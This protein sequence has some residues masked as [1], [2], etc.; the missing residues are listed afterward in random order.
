MVYVCGKSE[1]ARKLAAS[2]QT[3]FKGNNTAKLIIPNKRFGQ[4]YDPFV[5]VDKKMSKELTEWV[6]CDL[7][8]K[9]PKKKTTYM[10]KSVLSHPPNSLCMAERRSKSSA[11]YLPWTHKYPEFKS[12]KGDLNGLGLDVDDIFAP[13]NFRNEHWI[14]ISI[15]I[16]KKHIVVWDSIHSHI[17]PEDLDVFS[18]KNAKAMREKMGLDIFKETPGCHSKENEDN[19]ENIATYDEEGK[20]PIL[21]HCEEGMSAA[22]TE[23]GVTEESGRPQKKAR[24]EAY[25]EARVEASKVCPTEARS[26]ASTTVGGMTK[27]QI[28]KNFRD[29]ADAMRD[30]FEM[31]LKEI[32]LLGDMM[33]ALEKKVGITKKGTTSN[34]LQITTSSPPKRVHEPGSESVNGAKTGQNDAQE[35]SG[36]PKLSSSKELSFLIANEPEGNITAKLII[37]NKRVGQGYDPFAPVDKKMSKVLTVWVKLDPCPSRFYHIIRTPLAWLND[38]WTHKYSEFKSDKGDLNGLGRRLLGGAWNYHAG[39]VPTFCQSMNVWGL[40]VDDIY[41]PVN[42]RN[43]HWIAIWIWIPKKHIVVWD[44]I[45]SHISPEDLDVVMERFLTMIPYLLVECAGSDEQ[46]VQHTLEPYTYER[47]AVE[48]PLCRAG[49]CGVFTLQYIEFHN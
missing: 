47:L 29:I 41:A 5:P 36:S 21:T 33:E 14:S 34:D 20:S 25:V 30:G 22:E 16:P 37:P 13:V 26:Q 4:S 49:D 31:C 12:D 45:H 17:S 32:K 11:I 2:H 6:N 24:K 43:E 18:N 39:I 8:Y 1:K 40:D 23:S 44:I 42:F 48:V 38:G 3:P 7:Y 9:T 10:S 15:S 35:T 28:D 46:C 19:D 27:E